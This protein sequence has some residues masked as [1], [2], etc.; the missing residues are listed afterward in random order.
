MFF[1]NICSGIKFEGQSIKFNFKHSPRISL[2][3][4]LDFRKVHFFSFQVFLDHVSDVT[5]TSGDV[6]TKK[7]KYFFSLKRLKYSLI[8]FP[9][10]IV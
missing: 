8:S 4:L 1:L 9:T 7:R 2:L 5:G 10:K 3:D 6:D